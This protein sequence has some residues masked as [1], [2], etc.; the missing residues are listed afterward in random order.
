MDE[1]FLPFSGIVERMLAFAGECEDEEAGVRSYITACEIESP[2][3]LDITRDAAGR[4]LIGT[5]PP[6]YCLM[7]SVAP[8]FHRVRFTAELSEDRH[9]QL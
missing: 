8:S 9:G 2:V 5:T 6:I 7:T 4:L 1:A 3:E